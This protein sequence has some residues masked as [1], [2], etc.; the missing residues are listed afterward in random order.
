MS[1]IAYAGTARELA[2]G[3]PLFRGERSIEARMRPGRGLGD[4]SLSDLTSVMGSVATL[5]GA[6]FT[7]YNQYNSAQNA[8]AQSQ[9]QIALMNAEIAK[10]TNANTPTSTPAQWLSAASGVAAAALPGGT[11]AQPAAPTSSFLSYAPY[12]LGFAAAF[13]LVLAGLRGRR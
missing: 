12:A 6:A 7:A 2:L 11:Q 8:D 13:A 1:T 5:G 9:Q 3:L 10:L 4:F